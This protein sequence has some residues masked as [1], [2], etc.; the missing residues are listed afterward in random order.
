M[1]DGEQLLRAEE[2]FH[3]LGG[4]LAT[5]A[6]AVEEPSDPPLAKTDVQSLRVEPFEHQTSGR[7]R[8]EAQD[9][10]DPAGVLAQPCNACG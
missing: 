6:H 3:A 1:R 9:D 10:G 2:L 8:A 5:K 4:L 7:H